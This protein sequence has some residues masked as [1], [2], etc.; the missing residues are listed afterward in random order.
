MT[1][2]PSF[3]MPLPLVT[4]ETVT[5]RERELENYI[6]ILTRELDWAL[7]TLSKAHAELEKRVE[8]LET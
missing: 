1:K 6:A 5:A 7:N 8:D 4:G 2:V 3:K